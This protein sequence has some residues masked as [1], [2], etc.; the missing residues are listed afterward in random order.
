MARFNERPVIFPLS[1]P[2]SKAEC[3][4][5][6]A[7]HW[8]D[9]RAI[10]ATGSPFDPVTYGGKRYRIG[11]GNN[12]FIFPGIGL[13]LTTA[14]ARRITD[15]TFLDAARALAAKVTLKDLEDTAVYPELPRIRE[16]SHAVA[17]ATVRR[18]VL[19][20]LA[21]PEFLEGLEERIHRAMW[22]PEYLGIR[23]E[24]AVSR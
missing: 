13:G 9:G 8:S 21:D 7:I 19:E 23:Y 15:G 12:A 4:A 6:D 20:G 1:N 10:V 14:H 16:C 22:Y 2:T 5:S 3:T 11:Q 24:P 17:C 18:L